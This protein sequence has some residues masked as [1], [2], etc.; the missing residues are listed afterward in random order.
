MSELGW[1]APSPPST[2]SRPLSAHQG[3]GRASEVPSASCGH[4]LEASWPRC[5]QQEAGRDDCPR[6]WGRPYNREALLG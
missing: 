6:G 2:K 3:R 5:P 1:E 4:L